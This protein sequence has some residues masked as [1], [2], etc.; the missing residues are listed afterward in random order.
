MQPSTMLPVVGDFYSKLGIKHCQ[1]GQ[2]NLGDLNIHFGDLLGSEYPHY[3]EKI[4]AVI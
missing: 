1:K 3:L 2:T 4:I